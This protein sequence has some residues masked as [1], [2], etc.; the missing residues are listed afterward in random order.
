MNQTEATNKPHAS[1]NSTPV[2]KSDSGQGWIGWVFFSD[3]FAGLRLTFKYMFAKHITMQ[4][5][6]I[7]KW[8]PYSRF[9]GHHFLLKDEQGDIKCVACELCAKI[10]PSQCIE[11][12]PYEDENG[13]RHPEVFDIDMGRCLYCGLCE[14]ACP[15]DAIAMGSHFEFST[16]SSK[17]LLV[18]KATL[19]A[20][21]GKTEKGGVVIPASFNSD[22]TVTV[23]AKN[24]K[25]YHWWDAIHR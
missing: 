19:L 17:D 22:E 23:T 11:V 8:Q 16:Y 12:I 5:P 3:L 13:D 25:G 15:V 24:E 6:D 20:M 9:R 14:D 7:E 1:A 10:C 4:Y 18:N 21:P 2:E